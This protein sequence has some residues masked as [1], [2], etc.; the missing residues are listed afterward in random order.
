MCLFKLLL[1]LICIVRVHSNCLMVHRQ[2]LLML[3]VV[4]GNDD[5]IAIR[6]PVLEPEEVSACDGFRAD[7]W[8]LQTLLRVHYD[9]LRRLLIFLGC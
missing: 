5:L 4:M 8:I 6:W 7:I 3:S 9:H 2:L 1:D